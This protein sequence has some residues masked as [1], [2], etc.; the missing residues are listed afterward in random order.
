MFTK[1]CIPIISENTFPLLIFA[2]GLIWHFIIYFLS[3]AVHVLIPNQWTAVSKW[4]HY[5]GPHVTEWGQPLKQSWSPAKGKFSWL[6]SSSK[7]VSQE[8]FSCFIRRNSWPLSSY[9]NFAFGKV[10]DAA[11]LKT[12][13]LMYWYIK[14]IWYSVLT[15]D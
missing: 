9:V 5:H 10:G 4:L 15:A 14:Q 13:R 1:S 8:A 2:L 11:L 6:F 12:W 7:D 3:S